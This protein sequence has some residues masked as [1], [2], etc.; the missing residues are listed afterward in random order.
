MATAKINGLQIEL[1]VAGEGEPVVLVH[2]SWSD[3]NAW[4][5][6]ELPGV[7]TI[8][9]SRRGHSGSEAPPGQGLIEDDVDDLAAVIETVAGEPAHVVG[10]S[11]GAEIALRLAV[12]NPGLVRTLALHEPGFWT[13]APDDPAIMAMQRAF[14]PSVEL[15]EAGAIEEGTRVFAEAIFGS[16][17]WDDGVPEA[18][19][20]VMLVNA[21]TFVDEEHA[22]D[23]FALD[24]ER[25]PETPT[26]LTLGEDTDEA[27]RVVTDRLAALMPHAERVTLAGAGHVP[28]R[29]HPA[30]Y[31][32]ALTRFWAQSACSTIDAR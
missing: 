11:L 7:K 8:R 1:E 5:A 23:A 28:H 29:T 12:R 16:G 22:P 26:L 14:V 4:A 30:E 25:L 24:T 21:L 15:I 19:K 31:A 3:L 20:R 9:Y 18:L 13:L 2:G 27:C 17:A 32:A 6:I 10:N